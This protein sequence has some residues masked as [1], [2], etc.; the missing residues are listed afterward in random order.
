MTLEFEKQLPSLRGKQEQ[1]AL[2]GALTNGREREGFRLVQFGIAKHRVLLL[3][4]AK[5]T[6]HLSRGVQGL[7]VRI[8]RALNRVW[9]R[10]STVFADR[11][12][13]KVLRTP[14]EVRDALRDV[15]LTGKAP[16]PRRVG[17]FDLASSAPWFHGWSRPPNVRGLDGVEPPVAP[18]RSALLTKGWRRLGK[19]APN[20]R[21]QLDE[22]PGSDRR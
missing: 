14:R 8:A 17:P 19:L 15:L 22:D 9:G 20:E 13:S 11:F 3:V 21:P 4:E 2:F 1:A 5:D 16:P 18:A 10:R 7:S 6:G 12:A